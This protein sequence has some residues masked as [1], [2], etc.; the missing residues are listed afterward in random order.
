[1]KIDFTESK[2]MKANNVYLSAIIY[3]YNW[4]W[5]W[6]YC[7]WIY[8][9]LC[10][11]CISPLTLWVRTPLRW[12][13]FYTVLCDQVCQWPWAGRWFSPDTPVS[14]TNKTGRHNITEMLLKAALNT[15]ISLDLSPK[16]KK[17]RK[18]IQQ[19]SNLILMHC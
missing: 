11:Q 14:S 4:A 13:V 10:N 8:N 18:Q 7:S 15:L 3:R 6:S 16:K 5:S 19:T 17:K 2:L 1:M 9:Y 12:G